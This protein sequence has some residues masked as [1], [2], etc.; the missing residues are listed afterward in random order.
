MNER[1]EI[2]TNPK[3]IETIIK[4]YYLQ[5]YANKL[6]NLEEMAAFLETYK[7]PRLKQEE[8]DNLN[9]PII[10]NKIEAVIKN[11]PKTKSLGQ[12]GFPGEFY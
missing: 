3:E 8:I 9:R 11:L 6:S 1:G 4:N 2:M 10:S 12:D 5:L 7:R